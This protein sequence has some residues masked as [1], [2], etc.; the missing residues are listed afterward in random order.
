MLEKAIT[1]SERVLYSYYN[2]PSILTLNHLAKRT[3]VG[4]NILR[5]IVSRHHMQLYKRFRIR[6]RSGGF[7]VILVPNQDLKKVQVYT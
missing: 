4:Y 1:Q 5:S 2:L 6:K 3:G 7:R